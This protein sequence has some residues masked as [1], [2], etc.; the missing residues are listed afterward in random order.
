MR[1]KVVTGVE[2]GRL[3]ALDYDLAPKC[4]TCPGEIGNWFLSIGRPS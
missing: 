3:R 4:P 2:G 1:W